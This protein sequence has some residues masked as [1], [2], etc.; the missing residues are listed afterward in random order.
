MVTSKP[1]ALILNFLSALTAMA[2]V[3][4]A[5]IFSMNLEYFN[6]FLVSFACGGFIYLAAS[7]IIPEL[8]RERSFKK[9]TLQFL[10]G[11]FLIWMLDLI[12][13]CNVINMTLS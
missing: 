2:G 11:V 7:E 10:L 6:A 13:D 12:F 8:Q 3:F 9:S 4:F 5:Y 1:R